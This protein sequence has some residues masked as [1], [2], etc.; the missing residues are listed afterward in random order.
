MK[1]T[2]IL[3]VRKD[4]IVAVGGDGQVTNGHAILKNNA[5]KV[6][7][8]HHGKVI[9]GFAGATADAFTLFERFENKLQEYQG[10]LTRSA[11]ELAKDWRQDR[12]LRRLEAMMCVADKTTS[13][14]ISGSGDVIE[15]ENEIMSVG[16]GSGYAQAAASALFDH[17]SLSAV[18]IVK[19]SLEIAAN[20]CIYT[21]QHHTIETLS[22]DS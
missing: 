22:E 16:S 11:I 17:S 12:A 7:R 19:K 1:S 20:I 14:I 3:S 5:T 4:G 15:P 8:L 13:L 18:D 9:V 10:N 21:N 2:T 6:R